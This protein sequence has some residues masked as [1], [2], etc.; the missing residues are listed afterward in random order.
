MGQV[1]I[2]IRADED[3]KNDFNK[4]CEDLGLTMTAAFT[5]FMRMAL[6]E[7][8]I[9]FKLERKKTLT[10]VLDSFG[11]CSKEESEEISK[12]LASLTEDDKKVARIEVIDL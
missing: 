12:R 7:N 3:L 2:N 9:P 5:S 11:T 6:Q 4:L 10:S 1:N 8:G